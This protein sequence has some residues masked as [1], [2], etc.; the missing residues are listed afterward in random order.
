VARSLSTSNH[1]QADGSAHGRVHI[2][3]GVDDVP[4]LGAAHRKGRGRRS[5]HWPGNKRVLM[6]K[7]FPIRCS[8]LRTRPFNV[9]LVFGFSRK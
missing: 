2:G 1:E 8:F 5:A 3:R 6:Y 4:Q 9:W 7:S